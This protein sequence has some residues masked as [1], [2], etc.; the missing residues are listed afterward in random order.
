MLMQFN[1][2]QVP[3]FVKANTSTHHGA[4]SGIVD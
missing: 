1:A 4:I 3:A 2:E